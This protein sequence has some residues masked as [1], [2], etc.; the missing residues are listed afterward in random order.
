MTEVVCFR[1]GLLFTLTPSDIKL[2]PFAAV[3]LTVRLVH[4][5][6]MLL[7][8]VFTAA[9]W[10]TALYFKRELTVAYVEAL[11][12]CIQQCSSSDLVREDSAVEIS[13]LGLN[14]GI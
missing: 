9:W 1:K 5:Y 13:A 2:L 11:S 6:S 8:P 7:L 14:F 12:K 4:G 3:D 10:L